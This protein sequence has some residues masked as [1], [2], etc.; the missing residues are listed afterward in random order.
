MDGTLKREGRKENKYGI[1]NG[2]IKLELVPFLPY[3][4]KK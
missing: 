4:P 1:D 2:A 3:F